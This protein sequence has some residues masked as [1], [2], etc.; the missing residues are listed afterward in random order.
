MCL[1]PVQ[2]AGNS[3]WMRCS[4]SPAVFFIL[5]SKL[6]P[7]FT[8]QTLRIHSE[9]SRFPSLSQSLLLFPSPSLSRKREGFLP[10]SAS[11]VDAVSL[12]LMFLF[13][14][15]CTALPRPCLLPRHLNLI[16]VL[17][18]ILLGEMFLVD[19]YPAQRI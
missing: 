10:D 18:F 15:A 19:C 4:P 17:A 1:L 3:W 14:L 12:G 7:L 2:E 9:S 11:L 13:S 5:P 6:Y 8:C 16:L